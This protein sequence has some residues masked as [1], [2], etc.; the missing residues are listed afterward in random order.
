MKELISCPDGVMRYLC[1]QYNIHNVPIAGQ[2]SDK[3]LNGFLRAVP[4]TKICYTN[5]YQVNFIPLKLKVGAYI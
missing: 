4:D 2:I 3:A 5:D 1:A